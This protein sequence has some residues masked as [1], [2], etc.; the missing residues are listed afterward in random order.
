MYSNTALVLPMR[1]DPFIETTSYSLSAEPP[2]FRTLLF[3]STIH[4]WNS[5]KILHKLKHSQCSFP[6]LVII[7]TLKSH[8]YN[9]FT[10]NI[11]CKGLSVT[12]PNNPWLKQLLASLFFLSKGNQIT[13]SIIAIYL[14]MRNLARKSFWILKRPSAGEGGCHPYFMLEPSSEYP[15]HIGLIHTLEMVQVF[16]LKATG[17]CLSN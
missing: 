2:H 16:A 13:N 10:L 6:Y 1:F 5:L 9:N 15:H 14:N 17:Y 8:S 3:S 12:L 11:I 4:L 7:F